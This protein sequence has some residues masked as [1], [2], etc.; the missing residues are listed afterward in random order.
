MKVLFI[1]CLL[2]SV[3]S[4]DSSNTYQFMNEK[5]SV[6]TRHPE[7]AAPRCVSPNAEKRVRD[8]AVLDP[9]FTIGHGQITMT[10]V[11]DGKVHS[12]A[13][14]DV[15]EYKHGLSTGIWHVP[16][17]EGVGKIDIKITIDPWLSTSPDGSTWVPQMTVDSIE[18]NNGVAC[19][20]EWVAEGV[21]L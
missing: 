9:K 16:P 3:A 14:D 7:R 6:V 4:A 13:S 12:L 19:Y 18:T 2:A 1:L 8:I 17:K 15:V 20:E 21:K 11:K 10:W 5:G